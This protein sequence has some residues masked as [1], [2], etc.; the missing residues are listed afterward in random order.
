MRSALGTELFSAIAA[1]L[2]VHRH[3]RL[4]TGLSRLDVYDWLTHSKNPFFHEHEPE[5]VIAQFIGNDCQGMVDAT[6]KSQPCSVY[7]NG[8]L[9]INNGCVIWP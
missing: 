2:E 9:P 7:Q 1:R 6:T 8:T 3:A 4:G 5:L